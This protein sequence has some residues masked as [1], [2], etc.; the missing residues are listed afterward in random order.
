MKTQI[1]QVCNEGKVLRLLA[2]RPWSVR[3]E[4][5]LGKRDAQGVGE[6][7][8]CLEVRQALGA[9]DHGE[10]GNAD[11]GSLGELFLRE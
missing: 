8:Q 6:R 1:P 2:F 3:I 9:L 7:H 10:K 11:T 5:E 4:E